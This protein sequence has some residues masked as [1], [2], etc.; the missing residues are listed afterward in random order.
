[1]KMMKQPWLPWT[2]TVLVI[3][4]STAVHESAINA[5]RADERMKVRAED[6]KAGLAS[7]HFPN[8]LYI[9]V[10][11]TS[12]PP[13]KPAIIPGSEV[14]ALAT[15]ML[16]DQSVSSVLLTRGTEEGN[17]RVAFEPLDPNDHGAFEFNDSKVAKQ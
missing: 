6:V 5:A 3:A 2:I 17:F 13:L 7:Q 1:M 11:S 4:L 14:P 10:T 12:M 8:S 9:M 16:R 15:L